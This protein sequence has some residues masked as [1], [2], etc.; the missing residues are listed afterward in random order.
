MLGRVELTEG[1]ANMQ[2]YPIVGRGGVRINVV[3]AGNPDGQPIVF[4]HGWSQSNLCWGKQLRSP[5]ARRYRL[6]APD[7]RGHGESDKPL[8]GYD[9]PLNWAGDLH[10]VISALS[11]KRPL[12]VGWSYGG[13]ILNDYVRYDGQ[14]AIAGLCYVGAATDLGVETSYDFLGSSWNG[15]LPQSPESAAGTVFSSDDEQIARAMRLFLRGCFAN[16][17]PIDDEMM[18]LGSNLLCPSRVR[19]AL[20]NRSLRN[21][22]ILSELRVPVLVMHGGADEVV[23]VDTGRHIASSVS[24]ATLSTFEGVGHAPFW[25][26]PEQF[27]RALGEF[28]ASL[29]ETARSSVAT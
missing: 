7:L 19:A 3:E 20:F 10:A 2:R 5:L 14:E 22:D 28:A 18:M 12:L 15:L 16:P 29:T 21:D 1:R 8:G 27:N 23:R 4:V 6:V 13:L 24:G 25:E 9:D 17:L 11:L 26:S